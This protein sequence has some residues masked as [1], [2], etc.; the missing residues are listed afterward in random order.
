MD[1]M[2]EMKKAFAEV[3]DILKH[4]EL[5]I[6]DKIPKKFLDMLEENE[7]KN[8]IINIDYDKDI[9]NQELLPYTRDILA[10]VYTDYLCSK[11]E[12]EKFLL[13]NEKVIEEQERQQIIEKNK[14]MGENLNNTSIT[15]IKKEKWYQ[16]II[17]FIFGRRGN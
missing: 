2:V 16:K 12:K 5:E 15:L 13:E 17:K 8:Y 6:Q 4:S 10:M 14:A 11:E 9:N 3:H 7:D 1:D